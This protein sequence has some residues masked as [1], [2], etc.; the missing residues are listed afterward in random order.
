VV[1]VIDATGTQSITVFD[2]AFLGGVSVALG[3][4]NGDGTPDIIAGAGPGG[5]PHV[6]AFSGTDF[7]ELASFG[8]RPERRQARSHDRR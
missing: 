8:G 6:R 4:V 3:D 5:G 1:Q 2:P 7:H